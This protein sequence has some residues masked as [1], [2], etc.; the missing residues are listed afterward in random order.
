MPP[1]LDRC[2]EKLIQEGHSE[3]EAWAICK[4]QLKYE[5]LIEREKNKKIFTGQLINKK[6]LLKKQK[7][8]KQQIEEEELQCKK[9]K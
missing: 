2:V 4:K 3:E 1:E 5:K 8:F 7:E 9:P 6:H